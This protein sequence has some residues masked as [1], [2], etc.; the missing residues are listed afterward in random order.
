MCIS[1]LTRSFA[2]QL[3]ILLSRGLFLFVDALSE[4]D[5]AQASQQGQSN[6]AIMRG[7]CNS[8]CVRLLSRTPYPV[9]LQVTA[10]FTFKQ[11]YKYK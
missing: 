1:L 2:Y 6:G 10:A 4:S 11:I 5:L 9:R 3:Y 8:A 7:M